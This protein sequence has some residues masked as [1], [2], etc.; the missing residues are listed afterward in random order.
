MTGS[1]TQKDGTVGETVYRGDRAPGRPGL[2]RLTEALLQ[3]YPGDHEAVLYEQSL[4]P[5]D[6][7]QAAR[8]ALADLPEAPATV[9]SVLFVPAL[10]RPELD[11]KVAEKLGIDPA[12]LPA[13]GPSGC[14]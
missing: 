13:S 3:H 10:A 9:A 8:L 4:L 5:V 6:E 7:P 14:T 1:R 2:R 11:R 12:L